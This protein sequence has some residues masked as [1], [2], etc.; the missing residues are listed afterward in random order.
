MSIHPWIPFLHRVPKVFYFCWSNMVLLNSLWVSFS[1]DFYCL[2]SLLIWFNVIKWYLFE[3]IWTYTWFMIFNYEYEEP[4]NY[5]FW[6]LCMSYENNVYDDRVILDESININVKCS[7][8]YKY[9]Y[10]CE[11]Y[12]WHMISRWWKVFS[13]MFNCTLR[14]YSMFWSLRY[15]LLLLIVFPML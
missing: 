7:F 4:M 10:D 2:L 5:D 12:F 8:T 1:Y 13:T 6:R 3:I 14:S 11:R 9:D 15:W